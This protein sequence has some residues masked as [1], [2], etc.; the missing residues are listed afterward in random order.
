MAHAVPRVLTSGVRGSTGILPFNA[1]KH[2]DHRPL[3][4]YVGVPEPEHRPA[5]H[6]IERT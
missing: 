4:R 6:A 1:R 3:G 2:M 5:P